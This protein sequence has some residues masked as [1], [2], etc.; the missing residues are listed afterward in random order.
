MIFGGDNRPETQPISHVGSGAPPALLLSGSADR[1]VELGNALRRDCALPGN[2][3]TARIYP[4]VGHSLIVAALAPVLRLLVPV[5]RDID[6]FIAESLHA[7]AA[8]APAA[9]GR[10]MAEPAAGQAASLQDA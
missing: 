1:V 8:T 9:A 3:A 10:P 7:Q 6:R 2:Y 4:G 5:R